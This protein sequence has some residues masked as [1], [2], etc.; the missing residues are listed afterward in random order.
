MELL[1]KA[2]RK[3]EAWKAYEKARDLYFAQMDSRQSPALPG[4]M[5]GNEL[6][7]A[8]PGD[9][10][11]SEVP[12][13]PVRVV[14]PWYQYLLQEAKDDELRRLE[15]RLRE[16]CPKTHTDAKQLL[17]PRAVAEFYARRYAAAAKSLE[18]CLEM[19][20]WNELASEATITG[21]LAT[22]LQALGQR[23]DAIKWSRRAAQLSSDDPN[24]LSLFFSFVVMEQGVNG[25][26]RELPNYDLA[27]LRVDA[28]L[29]ATLSCFDSWAAAAKGDEKAAFE[30][31]VQASS[32][33]RLASQQPNFGGDYAIV[34]GVILQ[35]VSEKLADSGRK[36]EATEFLK[37]F[38]ADRVAAMKKQFSIPK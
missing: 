26:S 19:K 10:R 28:R 24:L 14:G 6:A 9:L 11:D 29:N 12:L 8:L 17:L 34:C 22:S 13:S 16:I 15:D 25:L 38:P 21:A 33:I 37:R 7:R 18:T 5:R 4:E 36:D 30:N 20:L 27:R 35:I 31:L 1:A 2:G 23:Q 3:E 32:Y